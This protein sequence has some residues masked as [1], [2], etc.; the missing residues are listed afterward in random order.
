MCFVLQ[1]SQTLGASRCGVQ[2]TPGPATCWSLTSTW[3]VSWPRCHMGWGIMLLWRWLTDFWKEDITCSLTIT[4]RQSSLGKTWKR[5]G[6]TCVLQTARIGLGGPRS[7][8]RS[9]PRRWRQA[10]SIF[11]RTAI[12]LLPS[13][14]TSDQWLFCPRML[15]QRWGKQKGRHQGASRKVAVPKP[16]LAYN[17]SMGGVDLADQHHSYDPAGR[18][19]V[20]WWWYICWWLLQTAMVNSFIIWSQSHQPAPT[21]KGK[22]HV[23]FR[24]DVLRQLCKGNSVRRRDGPQAV[25]QAGVTTSQPLSHTIERFPGSKKNCSVCEKAKKRTDKGYGVKTGVALSVR[26]TCAKAT[27]LHSFISSLPKVFLEDWTVHGILVL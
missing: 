7:W 10:T 3:D 8:M 19:S 22:R 14:R 16:V 27:A 17:T 21:R 25:S 23:D 13:G 11:V 9:V 18:L 5:R 15:S 6:L 4:S 2:Q 26:F 1:E 20:R 12:W 24:L